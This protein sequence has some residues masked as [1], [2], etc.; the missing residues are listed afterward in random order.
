MSEIYREQE[1]SMSSGGKKHYLVLDVLRG[2]AAIF[3]M[4]FHFLE[5]TMG[6]DRNSFFNHSYLAVDF[7]FMLSGFVIAYSYDGRWKNMNAWTFMKRRII[8][9]QPMIIFGMVVGA[10]LFFASESFIFPKVAETSVATLLKVM[11]MSFFLIPL[12]PANDLRGWGDMFPLN[13]ASWSLMFEYMAYVLYAVI[14]RRL[15]TK[16]ICVLTVL[17]AIFLVYMAVYHGTLERGFSFNDHGF[18]T[19]MARLLFPFTMGALMLRLLKPKRI[20]G[21]FVACVVLLVGV[22]SVP[23]L[24]TAENLL[25]NSIYDSVA[26]ILV[27][28]LIIYLG[29]SSVVKSKLWNKVS[30]FL[31]DISYPLYMVHHPFVFVFAAWVANNKL[32]FM[33]VRPQVFGV[34]LGVIVFAYMVHRSY[35]TPVR[36]WLFKV[37]KTKR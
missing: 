25:N 19:G 34:M 20:K 10:L 8:R 37:W 28:P 33:D 2:I 13:P 4:Q 14:L 15:S 16:I 18:I 23:R 21:A 3:V 27:F 32:Q 6:Y 29:A 36:K 7:F 24:G 1:V 22:M 35:D 31:G 12:T 26:V 30:V 9:L 17:F 11:L 5:T